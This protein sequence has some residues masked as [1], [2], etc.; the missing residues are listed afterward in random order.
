MAIILNI[1]EIFLVFEIYEV[2]IPLNNPTKI[3]GEKNVPNPNINP[4]KNP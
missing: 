4:L 1:K 2:K 3:K